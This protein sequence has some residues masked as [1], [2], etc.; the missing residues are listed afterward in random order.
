VAV[1]D[2]FDALMH[3]RPYKEPWSLADSLAY[4][5]ERSGKQFDP[6]V[7]AAFLDEVDEEY[8]ESQDSA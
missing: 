1:V 6:K 5:R 4:I 2:V 8:S 3:R 7:V